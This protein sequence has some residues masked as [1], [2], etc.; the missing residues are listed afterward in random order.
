ME[1]LPL[2]LTKFEN[3]DEKFTGVIKIKY[4]KIIP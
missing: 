3:D 1:S 4:H 2:I